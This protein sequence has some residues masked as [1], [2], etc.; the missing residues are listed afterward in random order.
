MSYYA[1][2][3]PRMKAVKLDV[4]KCE[5]RECHPEGH[6]WHVKDEYGASD[7]GWWYFWCPGKAKS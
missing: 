2:T 5:S 3:L 6:V 1:Q 4:G 7:S